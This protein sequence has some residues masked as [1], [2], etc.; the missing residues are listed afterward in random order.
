V[1]DP[2][3]LAAR[4]HARLVSVEDREFGQGQRRFFQHEVDTYG[5][6]MSNVNA[7]VREVYR[8]VKAW[9]L[10]KRNQLMN[11]LWK[12]GKLESGIINCHVYKR[13]ASQCRACEF[14]LFEKWIDR[15]V[16]NWVH[17]DGLASWLLGAAIGN[18][19]D[20]RLELIPWTSSENRWKRR[21]S[22]VALLRSAKS[23]RHTDTIFEVA[24]LLLPDRDDM[25]EKGVG[26]LL[27]E[28]YPAKPKE[29]VAFLERNA[30]RASRLT[31]RYAAE[32]M[33]AR[34]KGRVLAK[35]DSA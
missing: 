17:T 3:E 23:G 35:P 25:V 6:R 15:Y 8:E 21:A 22:A 30:S 5:V 33:T 1:N 24:S 11:E 14:H 29:T 26:W 20:L 34:D 12:S 9:P 19:P 31:L 27:K 2:K 10:A 4:I 7:V 32:K 18:E 16:R 28:T 13:F